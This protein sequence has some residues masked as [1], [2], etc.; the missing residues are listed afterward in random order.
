VATGV[1]AT[2]L[3]LRLRDVRAFNQLGCGTTY[4]DKGGSDCASK[5]AGWQRAGTGALVGGVAAA[6][7][8]AGAAVLFWTL[9]HA[10]VAVSLRASPAELGLRLQGRF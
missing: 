8:G 1:L 7:L 9:P 4:Q 5:L 3:V 2:E 10:P 6:V